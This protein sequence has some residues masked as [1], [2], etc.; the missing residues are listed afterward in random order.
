MTDNFDICSLD[1]AWTQRQVIF[2]KCSTCN[3][4]FLILLKESHL[5]SLSIRNWKIEKKQIKQ[6]V[7]KEQNNKVENRI[8]DSSFVIFCEKFQWR[9][10][11]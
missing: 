6:I 1:M 3:F 9:I 7:A 2:G 4:I 11:K 5:Y 10:N 8:Y